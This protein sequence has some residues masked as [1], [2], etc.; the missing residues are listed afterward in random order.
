[1]NKVTHSFVIIFAGIVMSFALYSVEAASPSTQAEILKTEGILKLQLRETEA[2]M[3]V[4]EEAIELNGEDPAIAYY[5]GISYLRLRSFEK[6]ESLF[7]QLTKVMRWKERSQVELGFLYYLSER[8]TEAGALLTSLLNEVSHQE[9][10]EKIRYYLSL[11]K[12]K[13]RQLKDALHHL[14]PLLESKQYRVTSRFLDIQLRMQ[15]NQR[16]G[17]LLRC[18]AYLSQF[19]ES[20]YR[21]QV[22]MISTQLQEV[23]QKNKPLIAWIEIG[24]GFDDNVHGI[25]ETLLPASADKNSDL[26][27]SST[28][29]LRYRFFLSKQQRINLGFRGHLQHYS[30]I[31]ALN[32]STLAL[33]GGYSH[34]GQQSVSGVEF[35]YQQMQRDGEEYL[36]ALSLF[37]YTLFQH[38]RSYGSLINLTFIRN[39][40]RPDPALDERDGTLLKLGY[41]L[42]YNAN[43]SL[44]FSIGINTLQDRPKQE[45]Y[46]YQGVGFQLGG[47]F[48]LGESENRISLVMEER[49]YSNDPQG[50]DDSQSR[51]KYSIGYPLLQ[52]LQLGGYVEGIDHQSTVK[53][54][55]Y[56][57][58]HLGGYLS[59]SY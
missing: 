5:L 53:G 44:V 29:E 10:S 37:P 32:T 23:K 25:D 57:R 58:T 3:R 48:K 4:L 31:K 18:E 24:A 16:E 20:P 38:G 21:P 28:A 13:Q 33:L 54:Y 43:P 22:E 49:S 36:N 45:R 27:W 40:Y 35:S 17:L 30:E 11:A 34:H 42:H 2:A 8:F 52:R 59:W 51:I 15:L 9:R 41:R 56:R 47:Q 19:P 6:A 1:M 55:D 46:Q 14:Q 12:I 39:D 26:L 50:R 7:L